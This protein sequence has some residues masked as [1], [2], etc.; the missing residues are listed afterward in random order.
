MQQIPGCVP[1]TDV[2]RHV[3]H[4]GWG[5]RPCCS[6]AGMRGAAR[7]W[8]G[9]ESRVSVPGPCW[10]AALLSSPPRISHR[11]RTPALILPLA[12][13]TVLPEPL[14]AAPCRE[15]K[16]WADSVCSYLASCPGKLLSGQCVSLDSPPNV[17]GSPGED[18]TERK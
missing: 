2:T 4:F 10:A 11:T 16:V 17:S 1:H 12:K 8:V 14:P 18:K 13:D 9:A 3:S 5:T 15:S 6:L 7:P